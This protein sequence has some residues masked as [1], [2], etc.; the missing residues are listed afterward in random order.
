MNF[1]FFSNTCT[2][3]MQLIETVLY[4]Y[5]IMS[6]TAWQLYLQLKTLF[7]KQ[8]SI[9]NKETLKM[10]QFFSYVDKHSI[11]QLLSLIEFIQFCNL[12]FDLLILNQL[13]KK[14]LLQNCSIYRNWSRDSRFKAACMCIQ[15][16]K[17]NCLHKIVCSEI[18]LC[19]YKRITFYQN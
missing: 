12:F 8:N 14:Q 4:C 13:A 2:K 10:E 5:F 18:F 16:L 15:Q 9:R 19:L 11:I 6:H 3:T 7:C 17:Q 1:F